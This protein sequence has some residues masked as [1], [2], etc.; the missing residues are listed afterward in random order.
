MD[1]DNVMLAELMKPY[2]MLFN[3]VKYIYIYIYTYSVALISCPWASNARKKRG[4][5]CFLFLSSSVYCTCSE[6]LSKSSKNDRNKHF[7]TPVMAMISSTSQV[8]EMR[9]ASVNRNNIN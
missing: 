8:W 4:G 9:G 1:N 2:K 5:C 6:Y 3:E 7:S